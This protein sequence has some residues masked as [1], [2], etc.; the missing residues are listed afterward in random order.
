MM[1]YEGLIIRHPNEP[2]SI[3]LQATVGCFH[4][5][6]TFCGAYLRDSGSG[7]EYRKWLYAAPGEG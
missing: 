4:R 7:D 1:H 2:N 6:C 3:L 5:K